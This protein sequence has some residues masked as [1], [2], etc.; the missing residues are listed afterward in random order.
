MADSLLARIQLP[1][2]VR[3]LNPTVNFVRSLAED[4][5]LEEDEVNDLH[6][7][8][9]EI[10]VNIILHGLNE[11][12]GELVDITCERLPTGIEIR[13][14]DKGVPFDPDR[15]PR[16]SPEDATKER[17][18]GLGT[19]LARRSL[20]TLAFR[21]LGRDG[22]LTILV[23]H[24]RIY[25]AEKR[26]PVP[27]ET[28]DTTKPKPVPDNYEVRWMRA[29][30]AIDVSRCAYSA[31]GYTYEPFI[32]YPERIAHMNRVG[33]LRSVVA[34]LPHEILGHLAMEFH[35]AHQQIAEVGVGFVN[36]EY[37]GGGV[38]KRLHNLV[39]EYAMQHRMMGLYVRAVTSHVISQKT[40]AHFG[41]KSCGI[42]LGILPDDRDFKS[43][44]GHVKQRV[45]LLC[46]FKPFCYEQASNLFPPEQHL[47]IIGKIYNYLEVPCR[48]IAAAEDRQPGDHTETVLRCR[49]VQ[50]W[51][52]TYIYVDTVGADWEHSLKVRWRHCLLEK[53]DS[54]CLHLDLTNPLSARICNAVEDWGFFFAGVLPGEINGHDALIMQYL[55]N[56]YID[57]GTV[58]LFDDFAKTLLEY[59]GAQKPMLDI[60][61]AR[62]S[63]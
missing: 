62:A 3:F 36:A 39:F 43:L 10:L 5:G 44:A 30:D 20:D 27:R 28:T 40:A 22:N 24:G 38:F 42:E 31:Y 12:A 32:Y 56:Q 29:E 19:F 41:F 37:R 7:A 15:I 11:N 46:M 48:L 9:E 25:R 50:S 58:Q 23:K 60:R 51:N 33:L 2:S 57:T 35:D 4:V 49:F 14:R 54:V 63:S 59:I 55:N 34:A 13:I 21:R 47:D 1:A 61:E 26:G 18:D 8:F 17:L 6:L 16:Y 52:V 45:S 53:Q